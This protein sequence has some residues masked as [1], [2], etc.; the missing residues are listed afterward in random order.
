IAGDLITFDLLRK[1]FTDKIAA[2]AAAVSGG[3]QAR[4]RK[5]S[6]VVLYDLMKEMRDNAA[7]NGDNFKKN[8]A[9]GTK[10]MAFINTALSKTGQERRGMLQL[11][12]SLENART[13]VEADGWFKSTPIKD[14][15]KPLKNAYNQEVLGR[16]GA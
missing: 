3:N 15:L 13:Q 9:A 6:T 8:K 12:P 14:V 2:F 1:S 7:V 16:K 10:L 11:Y 5:A 4:M